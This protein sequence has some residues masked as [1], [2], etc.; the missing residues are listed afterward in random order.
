MA[1]RAP[2]TIIPLAQLQHLCETLLPALSASPNVRLVAEPFTVDTPQ[3]VRAERG[4]LEMRFALNGFSGSSFEA[5][6]ANNR[7]AHRIYVHINGLTVTVRVHRLPYWVQA[8]GIIAAVANEAFKRSVRCLPLQQVMEAGTTGENNQDEELKAL[9]LQLEKNAEPEFAFTPAD[10]LA[11]AGTRKE[12]ELGAAL[13]KQFLGDIAPNG[14]TLLWSLG[15]TITGDA[16]RIN[17]WA[18]ASVAPAGAAQLK[19]AAVAPAEVP[20][21]PSLLNK[22]RRGDAPTEA[23]DVTMLV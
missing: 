5:L 20:A 6:L 19:S 16:T 13:L 8:N 14:K 4:D 12:S 22:K 7:A 23:V 10:A 11:I 21:P 2:R 3:P 17:V 1:A 18:L 15:A 9:R